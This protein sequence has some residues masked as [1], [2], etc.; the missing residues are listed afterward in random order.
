M[1][2]VFIKPSY[3]IHIRTGLLTPSPYDFLHVEALGCNILCARF[4]VTQENDY[5]CV[6]VKTIVQPVRRRRRVCAENV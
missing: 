5:C 6:N 2:H 4:G 3:Y 1:S